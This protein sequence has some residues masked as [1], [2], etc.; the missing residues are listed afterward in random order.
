MTLKRKQ[1]IR[2]ADKLRRKNLLLAACCVAAAVVIAVL[3]LLPKQEP[4]TAHFTPPPFDS[5]AVSGEPQVPAE[6]GWSEM[7]IRDGLTA[8]VC[9]VLDEKD[10]KVAVWLYNHPDSDCWL[11]LRMLDA[12]GNILGETGL[13]KPGEYVQYINLDTVPKKNTTVILKLMGYQSETYYSGG[14]MGLETTLVA[15]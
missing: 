6:L 4:Q 15:R 7:R 3:L 13:L 10:G 8:S 1:P 9:G 2:R 11:K 5:A 12:K 14:S